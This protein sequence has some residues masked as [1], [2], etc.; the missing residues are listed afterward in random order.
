MISKPII[1]LL[2]LIFTFLTPLVRNVEAESPSITVSSSITGTINGVSYTATGSG[3]INSG[4]GEGFLTI[5]FSTLI[6]NYHPFLSPTWHCKHHPPFALELNGGINLFQ[7]TPEGYDYY[8]TKV[9]PNGWGQITTST[10]IRMTDATHMTS[11]D[12]RSGVYTGPIDIVQILPYSYI[13]SPAGAGKVSMT[14]TEIVIRSDGSKI[15][16]SVNTEIFFLSTATLPFEQRLSI[17]TIDYS[18]TPE[19]LTYYLHTKAT[20]EP[21]GVG[22]IVVSVDK[23]SLLAPYIGL[24]ATMIVATVAAAICVKRVK[25]REEK[26]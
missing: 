2:L 6:P 26:Q 10:Q 1:P 17:T 22:G 24:A 11:N 21:V 5:V 9:Y 8:G 14:S 4:E 16:S 19:T 3:Y 15:E 7:L 18:W 23:S 12:I 25:R 13:M 20:I